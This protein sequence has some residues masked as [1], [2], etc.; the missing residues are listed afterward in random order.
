MTARTPSPYERPS[1]DF[2]LGSAAD[3]PFRLLGEAIRESSAHTH[4]AAT[5]L[6]V[7]VTCTAEYARLHGAV[8]AD[9]L[10]ALEST[11]EVHSTGKD[12]VTRERL[13]VAIR[14]WGRIAYGEAVGPP[15]GGH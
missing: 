4:E 7:L 5:G 13:R 6:R 1:R 8:L 2:P 15:A 11:I 9:Y 3:S 12:A 10:G 14:H